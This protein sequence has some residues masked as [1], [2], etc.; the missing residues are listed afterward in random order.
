M[1]KEYFMR[2]VLCLLM[3]MPQ[4][5]FA[6]GETLTWEQLKDSCVNYRNYGYQRPPAN[7]KITCRHV[8]YNWEQVKSG[9]LSS[10]TSRH[11][12]SSVMTDKN[13]VTKKDVCVE[14]HPQYR[15]EC[16][17]F[18]EV[19]RTVQFE[20]DSSCSEILGFEGN[21]YDYCKGYIDEELEDNPDVVSSVDTGRLINSCSNRIINRRTRTHTEEKKIH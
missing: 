17:K 19:M 20:L 10:I 15:F 21:L 12:I 1:M 13:S 4:L 14:D 8:E 6:Y 5:V 3:A 11:V 7:V 18:K 9:V 16:P 2:L